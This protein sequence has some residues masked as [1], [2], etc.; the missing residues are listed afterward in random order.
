MQAFETVE[1]LSRLDGVRA[2]MADANLDALLVM[3][4]R[5]IC[6]LTGYE[7]FSHGAPQ[8]ALVT[9]NDDP[10]LILREL[11]VRCAEE[12]SWL[13]EERQ[14]GYSERYVGAPDRSPWEAI[15]EFVRGK[16]ARD[17][18][19]GAELSAQG[20]ISVSDYPT[21]LRAL[22][23][24]ELRDGSGLVTRCMRVKSERE[25]AYMADAGTI[26]DNA[27]LSGIADIDVGVRQCDVAATI[28]SSLASG[29]D[30]VPGGQFDITPFLHA[31]TIANAPHFR[32]SD[33]VYAPQNQ[34][35]LEFGAFRHRYACS[36]ART[37]Y[38][39][40]P[41]ERLRDVS[42]GVIEAWHAGFD[43]M[44]PGNR[45]A[46]VA[47]AV[48]AVLQQHGIKKESRCGYSIGLDWPDGGASLATHDE[49]ELVPG[50]T[51]HLLIGIWNR[52]EGYN[53]SETVRVTDQ[54]AESFSNVSRV[55]FQRDA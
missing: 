22:G 16:V 3:S 13:P 36:L 19:V 42:K 21:L 7:G 24:D 35:N 54:G 49:T 5:N 41:P 25:L 26:V 9:H 31:G 50:M 28:L 2:L 23:V 43:I 18:R 45:C 53:F 46:D 8:I 11:D 15:G 48:G 52:G 27:M 37:A 34:T 12:S 38:L 6:Y 33:H 29:T 4:E 55:M 44:R 51:F 39:G 32:W 10:Y 30:T 20:G 17:A 14:I 40:R 47:N 1:F